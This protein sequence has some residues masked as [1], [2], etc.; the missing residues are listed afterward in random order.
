MKEVSKL[1]CATP[2]LGVH[3]KSIN[4]KKM[5]KEVK[6][7]Q[8]RI[9]KA[10][11]EE[12]WNK[13]KS[14][15]W[16]LSHSFSAKLLAVKRVTSRKGAKTAGVDGI[17]WNTSAKK[18]RGAISLQR[19][20]YKAMPLKRVLIPKKNGKMRPL[21]IPTLKDRAMQALYLLTLEPVAETT[22]D[23][24]S[25]GFRPYRACR[26]AIGQCFIALGRKDSPKWV[27]DADIKGCFDWI[28]HDWLMNNIPVDAKILKQ[29]LKCGFVQNRKLFPT[30]DGAP[31]GGVV[32]PTLANMALDGLEKAVRN[33]P[34]KLKNKVNFIR[35]ADDFII[36]ASSREYLND[37]ILPIVKNFLVE[38]GLTVSEEKTKIVHIEQGFEFLGQ[39]IRKYNN[40]LIIKPA[41]ANIESFKVKV[42]ALIRKGR[43]WNAETLIK[44]LNPVIRGWANYHR[45]VQASKTFD[46]MH[47]I[48]YEAL[49]K[50]A[51]LTN[52]KKTYRWIYHHFFAISPK[53]RFSSIIHDKTGKQKLLELVTP[54]DIKLIRY[55]KIKGQSNPFLY[56]FGDYFNMRRRANNYTLI[57]NNLTVGLLLNED[58][59][60]A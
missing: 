42:K 6:Q 60:E 25:Y 13:V 35:Y 55:I 58:L 47:R 39:N 1:T 18:M 14:L 40:K 38:R 32:S 59:R 37:I 45:N 44:N 2:K 27:L 52:R 54:V 20:G 5:N 8:M 19:R 51:K 33:R 30:R 24:N 46:H 50:W 15:Q 22:A 7:L 36:T 53:G 29:W 12:K 3:W 49:R 56:E 43:G 23:P 21:S 34:N 31:Q 48:I 9:A 4:W 11:K 26:D 57:N 28:S 16:I 17:I 10:V 41:K